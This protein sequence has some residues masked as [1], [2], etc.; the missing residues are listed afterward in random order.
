MIKYVRPLV[1]KGV[2]STVGELFPLYK[3]AKKNQIIGEL[4]ESM[5]NSMEKD[6]CLSPEDDQE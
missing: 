2:P 1:I 5:N 3:D 6:M 4:F